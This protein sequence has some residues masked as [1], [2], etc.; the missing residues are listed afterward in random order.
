VPNTAKRPSLC[1]GEGKGEKATPTQKNDPSAGVKKKKNNHGGTPP[2]LQEKGWEGKE[3]LKKK[4]TYEHGQ[5]SS[6]EK[7]PERYRYRLTCRPT[8]DCARKGKKAG[9]IVKTEKDPFEKERRSKKASSVGKKD[10][11]GKPYKLS[12]RPVRRKGGRLL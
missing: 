9:E 7:M 2:A 8:D 3:R 10:S 1:W 4:R 5:P 11:V 6:K 12:K